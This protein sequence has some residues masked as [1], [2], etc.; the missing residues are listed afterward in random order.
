MAANPVLGVFL[1]S[2]GG[3]AAGSFYVPFRKVKQWAWESYWLIQGVAAWII[4]PSLMAYLTC[5]KFV[6]VLGSS[7]W[8]NIALAY[9]FGAV[10]G[11][12]G[13]TFGL[14]MR[15]LGLSLGYAVA[16][17]FCAAA[18]FTVPPIFQGK[19]LQ[20]VTT[21]SGLTIVGGAAISML[22]IVVCGMA[23]ICKERELTA[24]Q[25]R[26]TIKEF[27]LLK[28]FAVAIFAGVMSSFMA[29]AIAAGGEI[30][31]VAKEYCAN[32][33]FQGLPGLVVIM[34][35]GFT[36]NF[37]WCL[38]LNLRNKTGR[39]YVSGGKALP[40][41]YLLSGLAGVI[42]YFQFFFYTMGSTRLGE[43]YRFAS[44]PIHMSFIIVFS[45]LWGIWFKEWKGTGRATHA[46]V[47]AGIVILVASTF[48]IG[49]GTS[50]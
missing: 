19:A 39:D 2:V 42:W 24:E 1:H 45:N 14:S 29:F 6:E 46:L 11:I 18:G 50:L 9:L 15:Y 25:A 47:W 21:A 28:G 41:N 37:V 22:G 12:G 34:A 16:L 27:A 5:P 8:Q 49:Y 48:V 40:V 31:K 4:M 44:W 26:A 32:D 36:V 17:G 20:L 23:G 13:L 43:G 10:W 3:L 30:D 35:G 33:L 7:P 38:I